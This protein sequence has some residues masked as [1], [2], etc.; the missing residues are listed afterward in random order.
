MNRFWFLLIF[1]LVG[2]S[3]LR[4]EFYRNQ[5]DFLYAQANRAYSEGRLDEAK[6][7]YNEVIAYDPT[8]SE[9]YV[10]LGHIA[11]VQGRRAE[12]VGYYEKAFS[13]NPELRP[14]LQNLTYA[15]YLRERVAPKSFSTH[16]LEEKFNHGGY[17]EIIEELEHKSPLTEAD[18]FWLIR[19]FIRLK[20]YERAASVVIDMF[21]DQSALEKLT[22]RMGHLDAFLSKGHK[23]VLEDFRTLA[24]VSPGCLVCQYLYGT[25]LFNNS[26]D[27]DEAIKVFTGLKKS[28]FCPKPLFRDLA[29]AYE[30]ND[31]LIEAIDTY[32]QLGDDP[33]AYERL[34]DLYLRLGDME[35]VKF[36]EDLIQ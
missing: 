1:V 11:M 7:V 23:E 20:N 14:K 10:G 25:M 33:F 35:K 17:K 28:G 30:K 9:A 31:M 24:E 26:S 19:S 15:A 34:K 6:K 16:L 12:A 2:C 5:A 13:M 3:L 29:L 22:E 18:N 8:Y 21:A 27:Y 36:Y 32:K 4:A